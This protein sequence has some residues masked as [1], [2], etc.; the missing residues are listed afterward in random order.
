MRI[1]ELGGELPL[2]AHDPGGGPTALILTNSGAHRQVLRA[3]PL[4]EA[5]DTDHPHPPLRRP[6]ISAKPNGRRCTDCGLLGR[7][8]NPGSSW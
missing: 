2:T 3:H 4:G 7:R 6:T 8:P 1:F 5:S